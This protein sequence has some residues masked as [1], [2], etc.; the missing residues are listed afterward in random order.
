MSVGEREQDLCSEKP[1][2]EISLIQKP[3]YKPFMREY[4]VQSNEK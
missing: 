1:Y 2:Q 4:Q 3:T